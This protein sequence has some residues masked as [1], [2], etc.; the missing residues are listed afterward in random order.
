M[1]RGHCNVKTV[2]DVN[3]YGLNDEYVVSGSDSGHFMIWD[4]K[5]TELVNILQGDGEVVNVVTGHPYEPMIAASGIDSTIKIFSPDQRLQEEARQGINIATP[6][7]APMHSS[8]RLQGP[9]RRASQAANASPDAAPIGLTSRKAMH[10]SYEITSQN[11]V[12][13]QDG[14][15]DAYI[16]VSGDEV[17]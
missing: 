15:G 7:A 17:D 14:V 12:A 11:D 16:T 2:K 9:R 6:P 10:K 13:R 5:T 1:Y 4:R 8:L 3:F